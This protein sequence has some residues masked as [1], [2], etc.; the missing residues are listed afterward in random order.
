MHSNSAKQTKSSSSTKSKKSAAAFRTISEVANELDVQQHVLRFW[1]TKFSQ[2]KP[3]KR[4]GGRRYYRPEDVELLKAIHTLL[5]DQGYTIKGVQKLL[6]V[7]KN[8]VLEKLSE[9]D[10]A[11]PILREEIKAEV[12]QD[13]AVAPKTVKTAVKPEYRNELKTML[14]ELKALRSMLHA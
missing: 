1:E 9:M 4:G 11:E 8:K 14:E 13:K 3:M 5:Y 2:V 7:S 10:E 12:Q 6:S